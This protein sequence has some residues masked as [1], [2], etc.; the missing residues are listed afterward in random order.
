[1]TRR[2]MM[3]RKE[4]IAGSG[5][6]LVSA[7]FGEVPVDEKPVLKFG[8]FSDTHHA[9]LKEF[10]FGDEEVCRWF[11]LAKGRLEAAMKV[12]CERKPDFLIELGDF[13][14]LVR[15]VPG[16]DGDDR[17]KEGTIQLTKD[18]EMLFRRFKGP[19]YHVFGNHDNDML[20]KDEFAKLCPNTGISPKRSYYSFK[21]K[22][23]TFIVLDGNFNKNNESYRGDKIN[24]NWKESRI[25]PEELAWLKE[26]LAKAPG[27]AVVFVHQRLDSKA[28]P[29][30]R[31]LNGDE[32]QKVLSD[33][34]KVIGVFQGHDHAGG[35]VRE[36]GIGYYTIKA[37]AS[38]PKPSCNSFAEVSIYPSG[39]VSVQ[40]FECATS[41]ER[42]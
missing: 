7:L 25:P 21:M 35:Y 9:D 38:G 16:P 40:G 18:V 14:D 30:H 42:L 37:L 23:L 26:E 6:V 34:G 11:R 36:G 10:W 27:K 2:R 3:T 17:D 13:K 5:A 33:S 22:G 15:K 8:M 39:K 1:M 32:V 24:W 31:V 20:N 12:F 29:F 4:F 41:V 19:R 28:R